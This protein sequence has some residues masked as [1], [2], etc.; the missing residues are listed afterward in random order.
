LAVL[1]RKADYIPG[2]L[3]HL[4]STVLSQLSEPS[5]MRAQLE[6]FFTQVYAISIP[7]RAGIGLEKVFNYIANG[8]FEVGYRFLTGLMH[9]KPFANDPAL[10]G[11]AG[12]LASVIFLD[13]RQKRSRIEPE[14]EESQSQAT[15]MDTQK[16]SEA[17]VNDGGSVR[18]RKKAMTHLRKAY[19]LGAREEA[20][21]CLELRLLEETDDESAMET[22]LLKWLNSSPDSPFVKRLWYVFLTNYAVEADEPDISAAMLSL[23]HL[24]PTDQCLANAAEVYEE[25]D[26]S[27]ATLVTVLCTRLDHSPFHQ[28]VKLWTQLADSLEENW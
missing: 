19:M 5:E 6:R 16:H 3:W 12:I 22:L 2:V 18:D 17:H 14:E 21:L 25:G 27:L 4:G 8:D 1:A 26:I 9:Q 11:Y 28:D 20:L 13:K 23:V 24:D 15:W 10:H 7:E